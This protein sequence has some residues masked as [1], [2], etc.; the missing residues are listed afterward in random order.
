MSKTPFSESG[1]PILT[2]TRKKEFELALSDGDSIE[3]ISAHIEKHIG[4]ITHVFHE[5][6]SDQVHI[7]VHHIALTLARNYHTFVSSGMSD[8]AMSVPEGREEF[9]FA[10]LMLALPADWP[11]SDEAFKKEN[12]YWPIRWLKILARLPHEYDTWLEYGHTVPNGDP[13]KP[14]TSKT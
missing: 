3:K 7:D 14:F 1:S 9:R 11:I 8:K 4:E 6:L 10:E 2:H 12:N 13:A 5:I